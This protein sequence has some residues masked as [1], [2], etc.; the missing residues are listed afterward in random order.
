MVGVQLGALILILGQMNRV[1]DRA[2]A[3]LEWL[4]LYVGAMILVCIMILMF[5]YTL[6]LY[7]H[8]GFFY[9]VVAISIPG[10]LAGISRGS[11]RRRAARLGVGV[12]YVFLI[13][14]LWILPV[15]SA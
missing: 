7:M 13:G 9:R 10:I 1:S 12:Y 8:T 4:F 3:R 5:E 6:R 15:F 14:C 2:R 11:N